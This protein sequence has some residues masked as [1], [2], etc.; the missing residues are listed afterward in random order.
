MKRSRTKNN[1]IKEHLADEYVKKSKIDGFRSRAAYKFLQLNEK[2]SLLTSSDRVVDLGSAPGSWSQAVSTL[3]ND[4]GRIIAIDLLPMAAVPKTS[5][6]Q[7]D[8]TDNAIYEKLQDALNN[9]PVDLVISDMAPNI[10]GI[11]G[12]DQARISNLNELTLDFARDWLKPMGNMMVKTFMG[13]G[14]DDFIKQVRV[15][16]AK[17]IIEKPDSSRD[18]SSELFII[19]LKKR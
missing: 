11:K 17:T 18:R 4:D 5:F 9:N 1:W 16:F 12:M 3:L 19:G 13:S 2:Y 10:S 6:I 8:F 14:F 15:S 7:G